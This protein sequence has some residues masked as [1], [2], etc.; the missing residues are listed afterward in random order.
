MSCVHP[1]GLARTERLHSA[2]TKMTCHALKHAKPMQSFLFMYLMEY[3]P[4]GGNGKGLQ[5]EMCITLWLSPRTP[6]RTWRQRA[7]DGRIS[8][9]D[10]N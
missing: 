10:A 5:M 4:S 7:C 8:I 1:E 9:L 6:G 2:G 3:M